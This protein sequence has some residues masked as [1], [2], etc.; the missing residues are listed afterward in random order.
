MLFVYLDEF[1][2][3]G[4]F[5][6]RL[7]KAHNESPVFG[8]AGMILPE[9]GIRTF[10]AKFLHL[11]EYMFAPE[12]EKSRKISATWEKKGVDIFRPKAIQ[13]YRSLRDGGFR[14]LSIVDEC[15]GKVFYSGREKFTGA[16]DGNSVGLYKTI[17]AETI[18][19]LDKLCTLHGANFS[20]V[21]DEH[22]ARKELLE[23]AAKTMYGRQPA[24]HLVSPPFEVE[25]YLNQHI[26]AA[27]WIAAIVGRLWAFEVCPDQYMDHAQFS[28]YYWDRLH[29]ISTHS[30]V[31][32]RKT[33][34]APKWQK[35]QSEAS[36]A[37]FS[38]SM[39]E[40]L[41]RAGLVT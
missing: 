5:V 32:R 39:A 40:A 9:S 27:D 33:D 38:T 18:R 24:R 29:R 36:S 28:S 22:S 25:S 6:S 2:H 31:L 16:T 14:L 41:K 21:V 12:I 3:I 15:G 34:L 20:L 8:L 37:Q 4:P 26:Q 10:G 30:T 11:K 7:S 19:R 23:C 1:G 35:G 17:L 13:K